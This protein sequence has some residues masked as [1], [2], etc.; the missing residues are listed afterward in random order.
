M[1][2]ILP[3]VGLIEPCRSGMPPQESTS[4]PIWATPM[5]YFLWPG[6]LIA[7]ASLPPV[8]T[9]P[10]RSGKRALASRFLHTANSQQEALHRPGTA[11]HGL[12][13]AQASLSEATAMFAYW[14]RPLA[15]MLPTTAFTVVS[16]IVWPGPLTVPTSP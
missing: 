16:Y 10:Y 5:P 12:L 14:T 13:T 11:S 3:L 6:R 1:V 15:N 9:A 7:P 8:T 4:T 2:I